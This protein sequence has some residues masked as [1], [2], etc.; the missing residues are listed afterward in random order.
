MVQ[1]LV[2]APAQH[3]VVHTAAGAVDAVFSAIN[4]IGRVRV[5]GKS[6]RVDDGAVEG[7]ADGEG[8]AHDVPLALGVEEEEQLAEIVD[9]ARE[10]EPAG[11]AVATDGLGRLEEVLDLGEGGVRVGFVDEGVELLQGLP[12]GHFGAGSVFEVVARLKVVGYRLLLVLL[13]VEVLD[14]VAG[15][16]VLPKLGLVLFG[17]E[18]GFLVNVFFDLGGHTL[19]DFHLGFEQVDLVDR[20]RGFLESVPV[21]L[22]VEDGFGGES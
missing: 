21:A 20:V 14:A 13:T 22:D 3:N 8:V 17:V 15:V 6:V 7:A 9:Q 10:L 18:L 11:L 1:V 19:F 12:D 16:F 5:A 2:V 4:R